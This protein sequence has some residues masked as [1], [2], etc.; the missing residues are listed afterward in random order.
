M[1]YSWNAYYYLDYWHHYRSPEEYVPERLI[2]HLLLAYIERCQPGKGSL[3]RILDIGSGNWTAAAEGNTKEE[4][5]FDRL[6]C[7][8]EISPLADMLEQ[9]ELTLEF[10]PLDPYFVNQDRA[11]I[12]D[13]IKV[14]ASNTSFAQ[15]YE[16]WVTYDERPFDLVFSIHGL[17]GELERI[18]EDQSHAAPHSV[19][20]QLRRLCSEYGALYVVHS[21][22]SSVEKCLKFKRGTG[23]LPQF[24][25]LLDRFRGTDADY[26]CDKLTNDFLLDWR[27]IGSGLDVSG[28]S[29]GPDSEPFVRFAKYYFR[30]DDEDASANAGDFPAARKSLFETLHN[31]A[32][33]IVPGFKKDS[34]P[35]AKMVPATFY[36]IQAYPSVESAITHVPELLSHMV[37]IKRQHPLASAEY[38]DQELKIL[39]RRTGMSFARGQHFYIRHR[40]SD[41]SNGVWET[42]VA[43]ERFRTRVVKRLSQLQAG[44]TEISGH[45][46]K[47]VLHGAALYPLIFLAHFKSDM[48]KR[49]PLFLDPDRLRAHTSFPLSIR[50]I[51]DQA[52][53]PQEEG[54]LLPRNLRENEQ[55]LEEFLGLHVDAI[56]FLQDCLWAE[57]TQ[58][59]DG[60]AFMYP[61]YS[62]SADVEQRIR[63]FVE[64]VDCFYYANFKEIKSE[65]TDDFGTAWKC[66]VQSLSYDP[67]IVDFDEFSYFLYLRAQ[68]LDDDD[69]FLYFPYWSSL[70]E[71]LLFAA[72]LVQ[73]DGGASGNAMK[74]AVLN[75]FRSVGAYYDVSLSRVREYVLAC[76]SAAAAIMARNKSHNIGSHVTPRSKLEDLGTRVEELI[77]PVFRGE[78]TSDV[79]LRRLARL[80]ISRSNPDEMSRDEKIRAITRQKPPDKW[81]RDDWEKRA[82]P[83]VKELRDELDDYAQRKDEFVAEFSTDPLIS[84]RA[85]SFYREII[86]PFIRNT[87]LTDALAANEGF[88]YT[89]DTQPGILV[90]C[91]LRTSADSDPE[92]FTPK[93][94]PEYVTTESVEDVGVRTD[95]PPYS[96]RFADWPAQEVVMDAPTSPDDPRV[97]LPGP[98][99]EMAF[100]GI[101]ENIIRNAAKHGARDRPQDGAPLEVHVLLTDEPKADRYKVTVYENLTKY[102]KE[103]QTTLQDHI[104]APIVDT[105]GQ[106]RKEAWGTAE[107]DLCAGLLRGVAPGETN[108]DKGH[109]KT[110]KLPRA[111]S[112]FSGQE[113]PATNLLAYTFPILKAWTAVFLGFD[114]VDSNLQEKLRPRGFKFVAGDGLFKGEAAVLPP[115][116]QFA[117]LHGSLL[118]EKQEDEKKKAESEN[119]VRSALRQ[120]P[121][122]LMV[123]G[124]PSD[125]PWRFFF[126]D[127]NACVLEHDSF[128]VIREAA[129]ACEGPHS[130]EESAEEDVR[131][132]HWLWRSWLEQ[133]RTR[134]GVNGSVVTDVY[135]HQGDKQQPS[136][137]WSKKAEA[138]NKACGESADLDLRVW[139]ES[140]RGHLECISKDKKGTPEP[141]DRRVI[142]DRHGGFVD[143]EVSGKIRDE[144][145]VVVI[146]K[147][148]SDFDAL[149]NATFTQPWQ[150]PYELIEAGLLRVLIIDERI[151]QRAATFFPAT[152]RHRTRFS[153][154]MTGDP[155]ALPFVHQ[156]A[157]RAGV[158]VANRLVVR[159]ASAGNGAKD[160]GLDL[161]KRSW[162][163][164]TETASQEAANPRSVEFDWTKRELTLP[165][166][167]DI[168]VVHQGVIDLLKDKTDKQVAKDFVDALSAKHW[169][170]IESGRGIP[171]EVQSN[172][173]KFLSFSLIDRS[174]H[175]KRVAK[176][177]LVRHLMEVTRNRRS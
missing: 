162:H 7:S 140:G 177:G 101:L 52:D 100:Y 82:F 29:E 73:P 157:E 25:N 40:P 43:A 163:Q 168:A 75:Y 136:L 95:A 4:G 137:R 2:P 20:Q 8:S 71:D 76:N 27:P 111:A 50:L 44:K 118:P 138:F 66:Y 89:S 113:K 142:I 58:S 131:L 116:F 86:L 98:V 70:R 99:G 12:D 127:R 146:D 133:L 159:A 46:S 151:V 74:P 51:D 112:P 169:T 56:K 69:F 65:F 122:R 119:R 115:A 24:G 149:Y 94:H 92:E 3:L 164:L 68:L 28:L 35:E 129:K 16:D 134:K 175:G 90:R 31:N 106:C 83:A 114:K 148:S 172:D 32:R 170:V 63:N 14:S 173:E 143:D 174:F 11:Y 96:M 165:S 41:M 17:Y 121:F 6:V 67:H 145:C 53:R 33:T 45:V 59:Q 123:C 62:P 5:W 107:M 30:I 160:W 9:R 126:K 55:R 103:L 135:L 38:Y 139:A 15:F 153:E 104:D 91:F 39:A 48:K 72:I 26:L 132:T 156:V 1:D 23:T 108:D 60:C 54:I 22:A 110:V 80:W 158:V 141:A 37:P 125:S 120:L 171:A 61:D 10:V 64:V 85:A 166:D 105:S 109:L 36:F 155:N 42:S 34:K 47:T 124:L 87:G 152:E 161:T 19:S 102:S 13:R 81:A 154:V 79:A 147:A 78:E 49:Y 88:R 77:L 93:F 97:A 144:D 117:I 18:P 176:I 57:R 130:T 128:E 84:T 150:L 21:A 167:I